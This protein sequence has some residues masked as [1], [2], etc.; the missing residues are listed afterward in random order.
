MVR[1]SARAEQFDHHPPIFTLIVACQFIQLQAVA[2]E[3]C[4][5]TTVPVLV[6]CSATIIRIAFWMESAR[7]CTNR[8][9]GGSEKD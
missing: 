4:R 6:K 2:A 7:S 5:K 3:S 9:G 1:S 8:V